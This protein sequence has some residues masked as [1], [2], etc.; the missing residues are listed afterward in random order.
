MAVAISVGFVR[1]CSFCV[2]LGQSA[3]TFT[4]HR[5]LKKKWA[6][7]QCRVANYSKLSL[8]NQNQAKLLLNDSFKIAPSLV[9]T[10]YCSG[11]TCLRHIGDFAKRWSICSRLLS[12]QRQNRAYSSTNLHSWWSN[13]IER[14]TQFL[15][16]VFHLHALDAQFM[17]GS[18]IQLTTS[19]DEEYQILTRVLELSK[20]LP[21][22]KWIMMMY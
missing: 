5:K 15:S 18:E 3:N 8:T 7:N 16:F 2:M 9:N 12:Q 19:Y 4:F 17:Q 21:E 1:F 22:L 6:S 10:R 20:S 13:N 11:R 14:I